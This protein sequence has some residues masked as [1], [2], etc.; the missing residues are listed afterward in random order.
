VTGC[1][2]GHAGTH[3][4]ARRTTADGI[5]VKLWS[6][7]AVTSGLN[8][9][10]IRGAR[11]PR[12]TQYAVAGGWLAFGDVELYDHAEVAALVRAARWSA[13]RCLGVAGMRA[14]LHRRPV[15]RPT[16]TVIETD[17]DGRPR[18][19][20]WKVPRLLGVGRLGV[21]SERG[22]YSIWQETQRT[23]TYTPTGVEFS[24][25]AEVSAHLLSL[26]ASA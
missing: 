2:C 6:D 24:T 26:V 11:S 21:W 8:M 3:A 17:R 7:G 19:R 18:V 5:S 13:E 22:R 12:T 16:W 20:C 15:L 10:V 9:E 4:I 23:G 25:L 1:S 14:R